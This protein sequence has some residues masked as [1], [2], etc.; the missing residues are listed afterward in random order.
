MENVI[1]KYKKLFERS[2]NSRLQYW[3]WKSNILML[4]ISRKILCQAVA[5]RNIQGPKCETKSLSQHK[6]RCLWCH[7]HIKSFWD[8]KCCDLAIQPD[9]GQRAVFNKFRL[10]LSQ[11]PMW[12]MCHLCEPEKY[13]LHYGLQEKTN[14]MKVETSLKSKL[15]FILT[16]T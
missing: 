14:W 9:S 12:L 2:S 10:P 16:M 4:Q 11:L 1:I 15:N 6:S 13:Q 8:K 5:F 3:S 7:V